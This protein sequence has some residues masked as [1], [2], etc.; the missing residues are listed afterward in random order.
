METANWEKHKEITKTR[1]VDI[2]LILK[3]K[4][5]ENNNDENA[6]SEVQTMPSISEVCETA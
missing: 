6:P 1:H 4:I 2:S 5:S 3:G